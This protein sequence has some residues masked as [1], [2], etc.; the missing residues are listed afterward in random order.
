MTLD[1]LRTERFE[2]LS[3]RSGRTKVIEGLRAVTEAGFVGAKIDTVV[4][5]GTNDDEL[6]ELVEFSRTVPAK[7]ASSSTWTSAER[8][9]LTRL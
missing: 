8:R 6:A 2:K 5:R 1:T 4:I 7:C 9:D 3:Q